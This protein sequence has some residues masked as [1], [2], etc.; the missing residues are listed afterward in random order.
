M[1]KIVRDHYPVSMLPEDLQAQVGDA[2]SVRLTLEPQGEPKESLT[3]I[4]MHAKRLREQGKIKTVT[5]EDAV[6]RVRALR[7]EWNS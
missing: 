2:K 3:E 7:D 6:A 1:N 5:T 4:L